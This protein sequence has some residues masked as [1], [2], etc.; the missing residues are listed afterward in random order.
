MTS[1]SKLVLIIALAAL[2]SGSSAFA[3]ST[4]KTGS[5]LPYYYNSAG[6]QIRGSWGAP[7]STP[8]VRQVARSARHP[9]MDAARGAGLFNE[10]PLTAGG[11]NPAVSGY[12]P[13]I[14]TQR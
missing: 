3:Q 13:G 7:V 8:V 10:V 14:E 11:Y 1:K 6:A 4:D 5:P 12:D 2:S 9:N